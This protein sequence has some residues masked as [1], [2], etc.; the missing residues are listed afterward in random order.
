MDCKAAEE[1]IYIVGKLESCMDKVE[2]KEMLRA[3]GMLETWMAQATEYTS[4][5][6]EDDPTTDRDQSRHRAAMAI[7]RIARKWKARRAVQVL[8]SVRITMLRAGGDYHKVVHAMLEQFVKA[9][10]EHD[11]FLTSYRA[12]TLCSVCCFR[13]LGITTTVHRYARQWIEF[14]VSNL[15]DRIRMSELGFVAWF[16]SRFLLDGEAT[17]TLTPD[18]A[19][20]PNNS[21]GVGSC[22]VQGTHSERTMSAEPNRE[23]GNLTQLDLGNQGTVMGMPRLSYGY[24]LCMP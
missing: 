17:V 6:A 5:S 14:T 4:N 1:M 16:F 18:M 9:D 11:G 15:P 12:V 22:R 19:L 21:A 23:L 2:V 20:C 13:K 10:F 3:N 7:Q 24:E 8:G